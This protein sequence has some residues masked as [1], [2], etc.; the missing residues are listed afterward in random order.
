[1]T[2]SYTQENTY[3]IESIDNSGYSENVLET[4]KDKLKFLR[5]TFLAEYG[6]NIKQDGEL[7]ALQNWLMGLPSAINIAFY[8]HDILQL[9]KQWQTLPADATEKQEDKVLANYWQFMAMRIISL[10]KKAGII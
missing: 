6:W 7:K 5:D 3:I 8:N 10:W 4:D 2:K 9:A 1:M